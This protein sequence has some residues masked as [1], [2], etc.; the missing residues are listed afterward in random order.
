M[1]KLRLFGALILCALAAQ[2]VAVSCVSKEEKEVSMEEKIGQMLMA[3]FVGYEPTPLI[4][5]AIEKYKVGGIIYFE[6]NLSDNYGPRNI[7]SPEQV[8][9]LSDSLQAISEAAGLPKLL[10]SIDQEGGRVVRLKEKYGFPAM[11]S[12][13]YQ[14]DVA[15]PDTTRKYAASAAQ[16]LQEVGINI[17][18]APCVDLAVEP[19][20]PVIVKVERSFGASADSV[21]LHAS[22]WAEEANKQG[23]IN[24][25]KHFPGHGSSLADSHFGIADV[26]ETWSDEELKP[27]SIMIANGYDD[28]VMLGHLFNHNIDSIYP[29]SLSKATVDILRVDMNYDGVIATDDLYMGAIAENYKFDLALELAINAGVDLLLMGNNTKTFDPTLVQRTV[30]T[31]QQLIADGRVSEERID[32]SYER[33]MKLKARLEAK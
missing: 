24:G 29:S 16:T 15:C 13:K 22:I 33:I 17:N 18:I 21:V 20:N 28:I 32:E 14:G 5:D 3:G 2:L 19:T 26:T 12:A 23:I 25:I 1:K 27:Y 30:E 6:A 9:A 31:I 10:I 11:V 4:I 8:K 7:N